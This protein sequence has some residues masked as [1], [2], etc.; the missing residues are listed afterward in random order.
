MAQPSWVLRQLNPN[1]FSLQTGQEE[2]WVHFLHF[3]GRRQLVDRGA[4]R[5]LQES[6]LVLPRK[7]LTGLESFVISPQKLAVFH[8]PI[9]GRRVDFNEFQDGLDGAGFLAAFHTAI[10]DFRYEPRPHVSLGRSVVNWERRLNR[11]NEFARLARFRL[12]PGVVDRIFLEHFE[13]LVRQI[14]QGIETLGETAYREL[15]SDGGQLCYFHFHSVFFW[16]LQNRIVPWHFAFCHWDLPVVDLYRFIMS[17]GRGRWTSDQ[18]FRLVEA[19]NAV[20]P[21][22]PE[23]KAILHA[24]TLFPDRMVRLF[25]SY[26]LNR[27]TRAPRRQIERIE[28]TV[29][30][31]Q[32]QVNLAKRLEV[33]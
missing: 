12:N 29:L 20:R 25:N 33:L 27:S 9:Q 15:C 8:P 31:E 17:V 21:L 23:E 28:R 4:Y 19:Y 2:T 16:R 1:F 3:S 26:Y 22:S 18:V 7:S 6:D 14:R 13:K 32:E 11:M 30:L 24:F 10:Q 5:F